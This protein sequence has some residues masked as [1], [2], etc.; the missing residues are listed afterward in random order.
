MLVARCADG[1]RWCVT[2]G[3]VYT[4]VSHAGRVTEFLLTQSTRRSVHPSRAGG[5]A[6][7]CT[8]LWRF[9]SSCK[10]VDAS[11]DILDEIPMLRDE[12]PQRL[13]CTRITH[14]V[15]RLREQVGSRL[16]QLQR[17]L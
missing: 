10:T 2:S 17:L 9:L 7:R 14:I 13:S 1:E 5:S 4:P 12:H 15:V 16:I 11:L 6:S 8:G 3:V